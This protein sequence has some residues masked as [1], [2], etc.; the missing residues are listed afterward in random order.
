MLQTLRHP[1]LVG[2]LLIGTAYHSANGV[3]LVLFDLGIGAM[4]QRKAFW[5]FLAASV[6]IAL[7]GLSRV[8]L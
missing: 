6:L 1:V 8:V 3:R 7:A 5:A 2:L 4:R